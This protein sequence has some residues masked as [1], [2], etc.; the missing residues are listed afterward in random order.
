L[1]WLS[2]ITLAASLTESVEYYHRPRRRGR[3]T[4]SY[5]CVGHAHPNVHCVISLLN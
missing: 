4:W 5:R 3:P 1:H 2:A